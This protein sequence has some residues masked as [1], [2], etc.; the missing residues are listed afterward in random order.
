MLRKAEFASSSASMSC[1]LVL[2]VNQVLAYR[3]VVSIEGVDPRRMFSPRAGVDELVVA[4]LGP[5][6]VCPVVGELLPVLRV[7]SVQVQQHVAAYLDRVDLH[8]ERGGASRLLDVGYLVV[9]DL[10]RPPTQ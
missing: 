6:E 2:P 8:L 9:G 10:Y 1:R 5:F 4:S 3:D 7:P